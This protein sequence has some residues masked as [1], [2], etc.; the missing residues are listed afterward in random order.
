MTRSL[1]P[2]TDL[3]RSTT[4][5]EATWPAR[6]ADEVRCEHHMRGHK[7]TVCETRAPWDGE[8]ANPKR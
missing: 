5:C 6:F 8:G 4:W 1:R 3:R 2:E 7:V